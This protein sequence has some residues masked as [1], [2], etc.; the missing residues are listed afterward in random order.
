MGDAPRG[1]MNRR[2]STATL[3]IAVWSVLAAGQTV[4]LAYTGSVMSGDAVYHFAHLHSLVVDRDLNPVN[5]I[6]Y[7]QQQARSPYTGRPKIGPDPT[8]NPSTGEVV[9]KY[10]IGLA[11][12][13]LPAYLVIYA[14]ANVLA[15]MGLPADVSGYG[16]TYQY[17]CA[18]LIAAYA[19]FGLW[20]CQQV[21][22][23]RDDSQGDAWWA[24]VLV[25]GA[26]PWLFYATLEPLFAHTL[27][28]TLAA[29][30]VWQWLLARERDVWAGWFVTGLV[31]GI[32]TLVRYQDALLIVLPVLDLVMLACGGRRGVTVCALAL[33]AGMVAGV[34]PQLAVNYKVFGDPFTTGYFGEGFAYWRSPWLLV[35]LTSAEVGLLRWSPIAIPSLV[36]LIIGARRG[37]PQARL[38]LVVVGAQIYAVG[39]WYFFTQGHTFGNRMLV[40]CTV[41]FAIG[42][43]AL[44]SALGD[45]P[46]VRRTILVAAVALVAVNVVLMGLWSG[47]VI[48]PL[49]N[50]VD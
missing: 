26:T 43:S 39:S 17:A 21:S 4:R 18:L 7:F 38:G 10:P 6:H 29:A 20:C 3:L 25:A 11:L 33:G 12:A 23:G 31:A 45:R 13:V 27:S 14:L 30:L 22:A 32:G 47:G 2:P 48:G 50:V 42:F 46:N 44:L 15:A 1:T 36:G 40:S 16:W 5:E 19:T 28:A 34:S 35:A 9:N 37:W 24:T 8:R 49:A 41:F